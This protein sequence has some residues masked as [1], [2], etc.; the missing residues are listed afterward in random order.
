MTPFSGS[1]HTGAGGGD[2]VNETQ[3]NGLAFALPAGFDIN[4]GTFVAYISP[5]TLTDYRYIG[6]H[7]TTGGSDDA[8]I[9]L[10]LSDG[11]WEIRKRTSGG[12]SSVY[13]TNTGVIN[14]YDKIVIRW[15][16]NDASG[17]VSLQVND[18]TT[19]SIACASETWSLASTSL[20]VG[21]DTGNNSM[22]AYIDDVYLYQSDTQVLP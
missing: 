14:Q 11:D 17:Y 5:Q 4:R 8:N 16:M 19:V 7:G 3:Q 13:T 18:G 10:Y 20:F 1:A 21:G 12:I 15:L 22:D 6:V 9:Q 2:T